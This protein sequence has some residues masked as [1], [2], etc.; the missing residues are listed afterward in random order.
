[1]AENHNEIITCDIVQDLIPLVCDG[2]ASQ[3][4]EKI[5]RQHIEHCTECRE[6][7]E[8]MN[9]P[10]SA[11]KIQIP[12]DK[13]ILSYLRR[14][15]I[16]FICLIMMLGAVSGVMFTNTELLFQNLIIMP[17]VG[18]LSYCCFKI[19]GAAMYVAVFMMMAI[20][21]LIEKATVGSS[22]AGFVTFGIIFGALVLVGVVI[23]ALENVTNM[24]NTLM[25]LEE[26][27]RE[28][29]DP[30][31]DRYFDDENEFGFGSVTGGENI[32][33]SKLYL[34]MKFDPKNMPVETFVTVCFSSDSAKAFTR[35]QEIAGDLNA[36]GYRIDYYTFSDK[37]KYF[38]NVPANELMEAAN[39]TD[40]TAYEIT[41]EN[42]D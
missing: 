14:R 1:M 5:V 30:L 13:K 2:V 40:L 36:L 15:Y 42:K 10:Q 7:L 12:D 17:I 9:S 22:G 21:G 25:R 18:V 26:G 35:I 27:F 4:S 8:N 37:E 20:W 3:G 39:Y 24:E 29:I 32:D 6:M 33:R 28:E 31:L 38:D 34:D 16:V 11:D 19:K 23:A 41:D